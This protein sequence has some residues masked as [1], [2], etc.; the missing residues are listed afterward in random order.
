[1]LCCYLPLPL[2]KYERFWQDP[3]SV[4]VLWIG[5]LFA[6]LCLA[7]SL[8]V[9]NDPQSR[10]HEGDRTVEKSYL[11]VSARCLHLAGYIQPGPYVVETLL[12]YAQCKFWIER[13]PAG[14]VNLLYHLDGYA[15][16]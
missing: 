15:V 10:P 9:M 2:S 7:S 1:M 12:M 5:Q 3:Y 4:P 13:N 16:C 6:V 11:A 14:E 8:L